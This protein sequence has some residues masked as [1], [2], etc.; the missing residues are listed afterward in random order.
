MFKHLWPYG[1]RPASVYTILSIALLS[2]L[3]VLPALAA[4][5]AAAQPFP[6]T[7]P[8]PDGFQPEGIVAGR[9]T[10]FYVGSL[11]TGAIYKG[12]FRTGEGNVLVPP[13]AGR[14]AVGLDFDLRTDYL[15]VAGHVTGQAYVYDAVTGADV[16]DYQ[17]T[18]PGDGFINDVIVTRDAAYF[19]DSFQPFL[20]RL[21]LGPDGS[22]P[23]PTDVEVIGLPGE[24]DLP[25]GFGANGIEATADGKALIVVHSNLGALYRVDTE[26]DVVTQLELWGDAVP[27]GDGLLLQGRTL[28]VVQN[29]FNQIAVVELD[30]WL[31]SGEVLGMPLT[32]PDFDIPTTVAGFG[33]ALYAVNARFTTPPT[34]GTAYDVVR[35]D[36]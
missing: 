8:L 17:L 34:P 28:Y 10:D 6:E 3:V 7:L 21:P 9:G 24:F 27:S 19:T 29:F 32:D 11:D 14:I 22:L 5:A 18:T 2:A 23:D 16:A 30:P 25:G 12:D 26:S 33:N 31:A 20:Y 15:F 36:K 13:H 35:V 1:R 4:P